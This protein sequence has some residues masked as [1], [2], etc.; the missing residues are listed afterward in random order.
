MCSMKMNL[1][2]HSDMILQIKKKYLGE[3]IKTNTQRAPILVWSGYYKKAP[4]TTSASWKKSYF[5]LD[6]IMCYFETNAKAIQ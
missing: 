4:N 2:V 5:T 3:S 6:Q 1:Y